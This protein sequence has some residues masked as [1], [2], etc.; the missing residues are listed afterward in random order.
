MSIIDQ[1]MKPA[2][3]RI[4]TD[5]AEFYYQGLQ[6]AFYQSKVKGTSGPSDTDRPDHKT[7]YNTMLGMR[8]L[9]TT[10]YKR[11]H[12]SVWNRMDSMAWF[13]TK[14]DV[15]NLE[16]GQYLYMIS[17]NSTMENRPGLVRV[18][19][20]ITDA[21]DG[22]DYPT[23][24]AS[25]VDQSYV[26]I[27]RIVAEQGWPNPLYN[28]YGFYAS[29]N[30]LGYRW[31]NGSPGTSF[32]ATVF[33]K[34]ETT[35]ATAITGTAGTDYWASAGTGDSLPFRDG[36]GQALYAAFTAEERNHWSTG[37]GGDA[38]PYILEHFPMQYHDHGGGEMATF[39]GSGSGGQTVNLSSPGN[40][41][42]Y[43]G[44]GFN[45]YDGYPRSAYGEKI[46]E[47]RREGKSTLPYIYA[48]N[49]AGNLPDGTGFSWER[50]WV[51][52]VSGYIENPPKELVV[53]WQHQEN[54]EYLSSI[55]AEW[56]INLTGQPSDGETLTITD[57][58]NVAKTF[59]F[60][61]GAGDITAG[62][63]AVQIGGNVATTREN[64][65]TAITSNG[66][67]SDFRVR[68]DTVAATAPSY[69][70]YSSGDIVY[71][72]SIYSGK[73]A[74]FAITG[75]ATNVAYKQIFAGYDGGGFRS[76]AQ[77][78]HLTVP[79]GFNKSPF[80]CADMLITLFKD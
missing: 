58:N 56:Q 18:V 19:K 35:Y 1:R 55:N 45:W 36:Y 46:R 72:T 43:T 2:W 63:I 69:P 28:G 26:I 39:D 34:T 48:G 62:N 57:D 25:G 76:N 71:V 10:G 61:E 17:N 79:G 41:R 38:A 42:V 75:S 3:K 67:D 64:L 52:P 40:S 12:I 15:S 80:H 70:Q 14:T 59:E 51:T 60:N 31:D 77:A 24:D 4:G 44:W 65:K 21:M 16:I 54:S 32:G 5:S 33:A 7:Y 22:S 11:A 53:N 27:E 20:I 30:Y 23:K 73:H 29:T 68:A 49:S 50:R 47:A 66:D 6:W 74:N 13:A 8:P 78:G 9:D 37:V